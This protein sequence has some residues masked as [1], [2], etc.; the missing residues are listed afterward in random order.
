[1]A[2]PFVR[3]QPL[4]AAKLAAVV[5]LVA[6]AAAGF[7]GFLPGFELTG[8]LLVMFLAPVLALVVAL[9]AIVA[10]FRVLRADRSVREQ[11]ADRP[12]YALVRVAEPLVALV[13]AG[14]FVFLFDS[15]TDGPM[16]GPGAI[17]LM[18]I[19]VGLGLLVFGTV[20]V[21]VLVEYYGHR[22]GR[23]PSGPELDS[24]V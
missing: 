20:V 15:F 14:S 13:A 10:G 5:G 9:E 21:R 8:L 19:G 22:R 4:Q 7:S 18:F 3:S 24:H 23:T 17:G 11:F 2:R 12:A 16:A 6:F 1:M